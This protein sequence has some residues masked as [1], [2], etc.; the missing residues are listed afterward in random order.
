MVDLDFKEKRIN[1]VDRPE[2][3]EA[4]DMA[5]QF[6]E[7]VF[8]YTMDTLSKFGYGYTERAEKLLS[9]GL[10]KP[11]WLRREKSEALNEAIRKGGLET[12]ETLV[13]DSIQYAWENA[14]TPSDRDVREALD[15]AFKTMAEKPERYLR[16]YEALWE[17]A[18]TISK[19]PGDFLKGLLESSIFFEREA[20]WYDRYI[21]F[22]PGI[23]FGV[24]SLLIDPI[25]APRG[26]VLDWTPPLEIPKEDIKNELEAF[27]KE[28][29]GSVIS[30]I[31]RS[32]D[33][34]DAFNRFKPWASWA[35]LLKNDPDHM[36]AAKKELKQF[37]KELEIPEPE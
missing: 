19:Y 15:D 6:G 14:M 22:D 3:Q 16:D 20:N 25:Q 29:E 28:I 27:F 23:S 35:D 18:E 30:E 13:R 17:I 2:W 1:L 4:Y 5:G 24:K 33:V 26:G 7:N 8:Q 21:V 9:Y 32:M 37:L 10:T 34:G 31:F 36:K 12:F 11:R